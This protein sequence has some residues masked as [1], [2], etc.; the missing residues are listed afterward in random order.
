MKTPGQNP[1][2]WA[3]RVRIRLRQ[4][5]LEAFTPGI[6]IMLLTRHIVRVKGIGYRFGLSV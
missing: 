4:N 1:H 3:L 2:A 6:W 5:I